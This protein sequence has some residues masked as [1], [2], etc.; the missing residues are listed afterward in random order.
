MASNPLLSTLAD[1]QAPIDANAPEQVISPVEQANQY[2]DAVGAAQDMSTSPQQLQK[3]AEDPN[4]SVD[5]RAKAMEITDQVERQAAERQA[6]EL[7]AKAERYLAQTE[8]AKKLNERLAQRGVDPSKLVKIPTPEQV[9]LSTQQVLDYQNQQ[10]KELEVS[11]TSPT[12][13]EAQQLNKVSDDQRQIAAIQEQSMKAQEQA[14]AAQT[15]AMAGQARYAEQMQRKMDEQIKLVDAQ[16]KALDTIDPERFWKTRTTGQSIMGAIGVLFGGLN[17]NGRNNALE[18]INNAIKNDIDAQKTTNEN[19]LALQQNALKR[20]QLEI[21][22]FSNLSQD[23]ARKA[24]MARIYGE[25]GQQR[26]ALAQ[27]QV[28]LKL[29]NALSASDGIPADQLPVLFTPEEQKKAVPLPNGKFAIAANENIAESSTKQ[30]A[31][32]NP[33]LESL[34]DLSRFYKDFNKFS[35]ADQNKLASK[36]AVNFSSVKEAMSEVGAL[37]END[38]KRIEKALGNPSLL[39]TE[40]AQVKVDTLVKNLEAKQRGIYERAGIKL[41]LTERDILKRELQKKGYSDSEID[42]ELNKRY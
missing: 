3:I 31:K 9:G 26:A 41:P 37:T 21:E 30:L 28:Q 14:L 25:L 6:Q 33:G 27:K 40:F 10:K 20:V 8:N 15:G 7:S 38:V 23:Q 19:K 35:I 1:Q 24:E 29:R 13:I 18:V 5:D 17:P 11:G 36:L 22:K 34:R 4:A 16:Q 39:P 2:F 42:S 32:V 12:K